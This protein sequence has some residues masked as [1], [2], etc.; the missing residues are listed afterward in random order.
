[1]S[2]TKRKDHRETSKGRNLDLQ[3]LF[4]NPKGGPHKPRGEKRSSNPRNNRW[5]DNEETDC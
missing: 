2:K 5:D 1:M 3:A 4:A